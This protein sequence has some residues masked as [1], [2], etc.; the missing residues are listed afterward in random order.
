MYDVTP[1]AGSGVSRSSNASVSTVRPT[2][3][4]W[5]KPLVSSGQLLP[6]SESQESLFSECCGLGLCSQVT[7]VPAPG[8]AGQIQDGT[9]RIPTGL[10]SPVIVIIIAL[11]QPGVRQVGRGRAGTVGGSGGMTQA[12]SGTGSSWRKAGLGGQSVPF[13]WWVGPWACSSYV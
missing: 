10:G 13:A 9:W 6:P 11:P 8:S 12:G 4:G 3:R 5:T 1:S 7:V 2:P